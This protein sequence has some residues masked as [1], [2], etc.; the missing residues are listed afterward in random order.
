MTGQQALDELR[1]SD[2]PTSVI[3]DVPRL[4]F[5]VMNLLLGNDL[6]QVCP[7]YFHSH[8]LVCSVRVEPFSKDPISFADASSV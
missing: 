7:H 4:E 6:L 8:R 5:N 2:G 1:R 3:I